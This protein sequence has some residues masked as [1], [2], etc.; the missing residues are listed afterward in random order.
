MSDGQDV[1][2]LVNCFFWYQ[3]TRVVPDRRPL[4][5]CVFVCV[6]YYAVCIVCGKDLKTVECP[7]ASLSVSSIDSRSNGQRVCLQWVCC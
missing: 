4:N 7:S 2:E 5:G 3:P 1:C 6:L